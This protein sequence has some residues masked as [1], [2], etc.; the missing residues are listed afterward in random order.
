MS[1]HFRVLEVKVKEKRKTYFDILRLVAIFLVIFNH[2]NG[3]SLYMESEGY[4]TW[5]YMFITMLTRINVPLFFMISGALLLPKDEKISIVIKE[6]VYRFVVITIFANSLI[7][8]IRSG[9][10]GAN[11]GGMISGICTGKIE[12]SYWYLYAYIGFLLLLPCLRKMVVNLNEKDFF[13]IFVLHIVFLTVIPAVNYILVV[14]Y[15]LSISVSTDLKIPLVVEKSFFYPIMGYY[16]DKILDMSKIKMKTIVRLLG[17]SF[18]GI[19]ISSMFTYHEGMRIGFTQNF[20]H[21]F[22]YVT[23][24]SCFVTVKYL[25][26]KRIIGERG[27]ALIS[28]GGTLT[29]G[30]Y[31][32]DPVLKH[33]F[34]TRYTSLI[35]DIF[36]SLVVALTWCIFSM[37]VGGLLTYILKKFPVI[38]K[39]I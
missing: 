22:D 18:I 24:I 21:L 1:M 34:Y 23:T 9:I 13:W 19:V 37:I 8:L 20:V 2:T 12:G 38:R 26:S 30:M 7:Y 5:L 32:F 36:P 15:N 3:Y 10:V 28:L 6:R 39:F 35:N 25:F 29:F 14:K 27:H 31:L 33:F 11:I 17:V 16:M 4:K